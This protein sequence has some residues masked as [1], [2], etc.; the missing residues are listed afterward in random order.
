MTNLDSI[1][2]KANT[3]ESLSYKT[4]MPMSLYVILSTF[5]FSFAGYV[6]AKTF[7]YH[8]GVRVENFF[9]FEDYI[10]NSV[11][12]VYIA[13]IPILFNLIVISVVK[14]PKIPERFLDVS[15]GAVKGEGMTNIE[16]KMKILKLL[17]V[18]LKVFLITLYAAPIIICIYEF[19]SGGSEKYIV[20]MGVANF[21]G[22]QFF[23][24]AKRK[25]IF[26]LNTMD[27]FFFTTCF[28]FLVAVYCMAHFGAHMIK[29]DTYAYKNLKKSVTVVQYELKA[30]EPE[31]FIHIGSTNQFMFL[32]DRK[33]SCTFVVPMSDFVKAKITLVDN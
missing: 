14:V 7:Y 26:G 32:F 12:V 30:K 2:K 33:D 22:T 16:R 3:D 27:W 4:K 15:H 20:Y 9:A 23:L 11:D 10:R 8:F 6:Y 1:D 25:K 24:L 31:E 21:F 18:S 19:Y 29:K 28:G 13:I 17:D 5:I